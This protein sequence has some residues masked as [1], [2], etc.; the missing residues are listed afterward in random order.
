MI[1]CH[2]QAPQL[3]A[4]H[5]LRPCGALSSSSSTT[6]ISR[7]SESCYCYQHVC[8]ILALTAGEEMS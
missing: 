6:F 4:T 7:D 8:Q 5:T 2:G 3:Q 1:N